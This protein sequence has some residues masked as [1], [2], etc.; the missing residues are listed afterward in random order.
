MRDGG[1]QEEVNGNGG[2][3]NGGNGGNGNG[4]ENGGGNG[5]NFGVGMEKAPKPMGKTETQ[6]GWVRFGD[7]LAGLDTGSGRNILFS[8][9][10]VQLRVLLQYENNCGLRPPMPRVRQNYEVVMTKVYLSKKRGP[11]DNMARAYTAGNNEK[12][13]VKLDLFHM[14]QCKIW[15]YAGRVVRPDH[16]RKDCPKLRNQN[17][18]NKT[19]NKNGNKSGNQ[20]G[21]NEA[22]A[23]AYSIGG[24]GANPDS[25]VFSTSHRYGLV[26][27]VPRAQVTSKKTEDQSKEKRLEDVSIVTEKYPKVI[28]RRLAWANRLHA[29][30]FQIDLVPG[31]APVARAPYRLAPAELQELSTRLAPAKMQELS[32][33]LQ[34]LYDRGFIRPSSL[35]WGAPVL[36]VK[37]KDG[38]FW[39]C[40]DYR[41]LNKLT[42]KNRYPLPRIDDLFDQLQGLR[43]Y[44]KI[45]LRSSY[46]QLRFREE[47]ISKTAFRTRYGHYE[48]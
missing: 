16:F 37:K 34:E 9:V 26:S 48:F 27:E 4:N 12:K 32:T 30:R 14:Q 10:R 13:G 24:G 42:V 17:R 45:D 19:R 38:S 47:D 22:T 7:G 31:A 1:G 40:I 18:R 28:H 43:V 25:N 11:K 8:W 41:K 46:H 23:K 39:M 21:G 29:V 6:T 44:F 20:T 33:Q 3:G 36:F 35:P 5:Y 15:H 2:N